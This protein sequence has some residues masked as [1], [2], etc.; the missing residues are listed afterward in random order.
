MEL[1]TK[2][3]FNELIKESKLTLVDFYATWCGPCKMLSPIIDSVSNKLSNEINI[4][5]VNIDSFNDL[6]SENHV[7]SVPTLI[8]FK[9]GQEIYRRSGFID[10]SNLIDLIKKNM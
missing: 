9:A 10:E 2:N 8:F 7:Q 1:E 6:A 3:Q 5:K 4:L